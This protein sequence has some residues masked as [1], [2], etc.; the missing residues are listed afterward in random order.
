MAVLIRASTGTRSHSDEPKKS[1]QGT[2]KSRKWKNTVSEVAGNKYIYYKRYLGKRAHAVMS[3]FTSWRRGVG[4]SC[5]QRGPFLGKSKECPIF[6]W[7]LFSPVLFSRRGLGS[8]HPFQKKCAGRKGGW[9][10]RDILYVLIAYINVTA[11][12]RNHTNLRKQ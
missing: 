12:I 7:P 6:V 4:S 9:H 11:K 5:S 2:V 3:S 1:H 8:E 10:K